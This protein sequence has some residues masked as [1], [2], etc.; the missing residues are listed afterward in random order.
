MK[1]IDLTLRLEDG[2]V[3]YPWDP[4]LSITEVSTLQDDWRNMRKLTCV[5]HDGTHVNAPIHSKA[6]W[7]NLD[8]YT[9]DD[10]IWESVLYTCEDD[11][12]AWLWIIFHKHDIDFHIA[13][14]IIRKRPKFIWLSA[15]FEFNIEVEK[16]LLEHDIISFERL[17]NT[18]ALPKK[19]IFHWAPLKI[20]KWDGSPVR[21][22]AI[23]HDT[24]S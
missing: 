18:E 6:L 21:A 8:D 15:H 19:F 24:I 22:Y 4:A 1:I 11:I 23:I 9:L 13:D 10:F 17:A 2:K 12:Q 14:I 16:Y 5:S 3:Y 20:E 7:K